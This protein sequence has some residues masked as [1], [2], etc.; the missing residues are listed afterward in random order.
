MSIDSPPRA[1][2]RLLR[3]RPSA[4]EPADEAVRT[5]E[6]PRLPARRNPKWIALGAIAICLGGLLSYV[7]YARVASS[8]SVVIMAHTVYRGA[9][10]Q[11]SDLAV[12]RM[13]GEIVAKSV[14]AAQLD[15]LVGQR[16]VFDLPE[17]ALVTPG[18]YAQ[19]AVPAAGRAI[20]G[21]RLSTG[22]A[23]AGLLTPSATVRL[24]G[25]PAAASADTKADDR[26]G[27]KTF[28]GSIVDQTAGADGDSIVVDVDVAAAEAPTIALLAAQDRL[29]VVREPER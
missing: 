25:L 5:P 3:S 18:S 14:P 16:A 13:S 12:A 28:E 27:G 21:I 1:G 29:A 11:Q 23:P 26:L 6:P 22:R 17:G 7:I 10:I 15:S 9:T 19:L 2:R 20:V 4:E 8:T 24:V